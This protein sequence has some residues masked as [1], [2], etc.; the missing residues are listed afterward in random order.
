MHNIQKIIDSI[1]A[2]AYNRNYKLINLITREEIGDNNLNAQLKKVERYSYVNFE[3]IVGEMQQYITTIKFGI[4][5]KM[6]S[7]ISVYNV[8][9]YNKQQCAGIAAHVLGGDYTKFYLNKTIENRLLSDPDNFFHVRDM[10]IPYHVFQDYHR[11][12]ERHDKV[13]H[14]I[15]C[16]GQI[17]PSA[18]AAAQVVAPDNL[19]DAGKYKWVLEQIKIPDSGYFYLPKP[20]SKRQPATRPYVQIDGDT[21]F[22]IRQAAKATH[23]YFGL[24]MSS[25]EQFIAKQLKDGNP[26]FRLIPRSEIKPEQLK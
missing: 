2:S 14:P 20:P 13:T 6:F 24:T 15:S 22:S 10:A 7:P 5:P 18:R 16:K 1:P 4:T 23:R 12:S 26:R 25:T 9:F 3:S 21:Y 19:N 8:I 17:F 11:S